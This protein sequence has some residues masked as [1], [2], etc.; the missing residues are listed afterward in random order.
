[1]V[2]RGGAPIRGLDPEYSVL[3][4][5]GDER[6]SSMGGYGLFSIFNVAICRGRSLVLLCVA[7]CKPH[8]ADCKM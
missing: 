1:M 8:S 5:V 3:G 2:C 4:P 7:T 6:D